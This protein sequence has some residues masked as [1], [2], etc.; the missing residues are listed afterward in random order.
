LALT[1]RCNERYAIVQTSNRE[2]GDRHSV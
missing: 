1:Q 2:Y